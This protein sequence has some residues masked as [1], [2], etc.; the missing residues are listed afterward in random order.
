MTPSAM[1]DSTS[2]CSTFGEIIHS[3]SIDG[4]AAL[5]HVGLPNSGWVNS[6]AGEELLHLPPGSTDKWLGI[7]RFRDGTPPSGSPIPSH[8]S[9]SQLLV[10][11]GVLGEED[12]LGV[13]RY[14][15]RHKPVRTPSTKGATITAEG[16]GEQRG[17]L[18]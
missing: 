4:H 7:T 6:G 16:L 2:Q 8:D 11:P 10:L 3:P 13:R 1:A 5:Q 15:I 12:E 18:C 9:L 17:P 14:D